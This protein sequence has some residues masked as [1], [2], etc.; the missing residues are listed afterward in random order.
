MARVARWSLRTKSQQCRTNDF[1]ILSYLLHLQRKSPL[2]L[3]GPLHL[4]K[5]GHR[6]FN[7][8]TCCLVYFL[9]FGN[10]FFAGYFHAAI[11]RPWQFTTSRKSAPGEVPRVREQQRGLTPGP[12]VALSESVPT[13]P[14]TALSRSAS[15]EASS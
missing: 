12:A 13:S 8:P 7:I 1:L 9:A 10:G 4:L 2:T 15:A 11:M 5:H 3:A 6:L 14:G